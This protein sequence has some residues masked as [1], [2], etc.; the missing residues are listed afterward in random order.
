[1]KDLTRRDFLRLAA[2]GLGNVFL[3]DGYSPAVCHRGHY[4]RLAHLGRYPGFAA[5]IRCSPDSQAERSGR[6]LGH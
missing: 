5:L 4:R 1:M 2:A 6:W 3:V